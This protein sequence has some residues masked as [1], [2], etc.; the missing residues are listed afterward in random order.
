MY[1]KILVP[2]GGTERSLTA[3]H[4]AAGLAKSENAQLLILHVRS[5]IDAPRHVEG[6]ALSRLPPEVV[7]QEVEAQERKAL[8]SAMRHA[9]DAGVQAE[10]AFVYGYSVYQTIL[11]VAAAE[12]CDLIVMA[13]HGRRS[14][15]AGLLLGNETQKLLMHARIPVL[16]VR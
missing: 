12:G 10:M 1:K 15:L 6:G 8:E 16:V 4:E 7:M 2:T 5:P 13:S 3:V 11:N 9:A 14:G